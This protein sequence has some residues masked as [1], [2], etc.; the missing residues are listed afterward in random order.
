MMA[1][2][3][4]TEL[5]DTEIAGADAARQLQIGLEY[6][7]AGKIDEA[8]TAYQ[9]GLAA[10]ESESS[11]RVSTETISELHANLGN[12]CMLRGNLEFAAENYKAALRLA[13]HLTFCWCNL[14]NVNLKTG[15]PQEA[16]TLYL[17]A[18]T[19]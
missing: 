1:L 7:G 5:P 10:V 16:I 17:Q 14:G 12:A 6:Y 19:L 9:Q 15:K 11:G 4:G 3:L 18:L 2:A 8:M 13:P